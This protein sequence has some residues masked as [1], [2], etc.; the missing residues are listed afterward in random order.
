MAFQI[1]QTFKFGELDYSYDRKGDV[2]DMSFGPPAPSIALQVEDWLAMRIRV[3]PPALAGMTVVGFRK[4]FEKINRYAEK[5]LPQR[6]KRLARVEMSIAYDDGS[7]TLIMRFEEKPS[8]L[9]RLRQ[10]FRLRDT[11]QASVF[12]PLAGRGDVP[13][14]PG[15]SA[16]ALENVYVEKSVP[17]KDFIGIKIL[18]YTK[19]GP[20]A[21]EGILGAI[22]D[23]L[24]EPDTA[25]GENIHLIT[26]V[27]FRHLDWQKFAAL[28]A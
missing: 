17:S 23:T 26:T 25:Q 24:F 19:C 10:R 18:Q 8:F 5:E 2:L 9:K 21:F 11:G 22:I 12:E 16:G 13:P 20:A 27:L 1:V 15:S 3:S 7:D 4:I 6:M 14:T 28:A